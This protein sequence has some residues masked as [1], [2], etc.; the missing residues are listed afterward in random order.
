MRVLYSNTEV[1]RGKPIVKASPVGDGGEPWVAIYPTGKG[2]YPEL[3]PD[4]PHLAMSVEDWIELR[5]AVDRHIAD[6]GK[7]SGTD[8]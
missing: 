5:T 4:E 3:P 8:V 2:E 6:R 7:S 1:K